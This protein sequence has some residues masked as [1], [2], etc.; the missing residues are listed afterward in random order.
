MLSPNA[1]CQFASKLKNQ[2]RSVEQTID[3][4]LDGIHPCAGSV[5][6]VG[7]VCFLEICAAGPQASNILLCTVLVSTQDLLKKRVDRCLSGLSRLSLCSAA[8]ISTGLSKSSRSGSTQD[9]GDGIP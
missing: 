7:N 1:G 9:I 4:V 2:G 3:T 8:T 6:D 5:Y